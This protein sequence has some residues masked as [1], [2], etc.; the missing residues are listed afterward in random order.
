AADAASAGPIQTSSGSVAVAV[1]KVQTVAA[2]ADAAADTTSS[3][4][5]TEIVVTGSRIPQ[6]NLTSVSPIQAV[7]HQEFQLTGHTDVIDLLNTLPQNFQNNKND[8]S[9]TSNPLNGPGGVSTA[10][11]RGLGPQRTLV[12]VNG[13]R[14]GIGDPDTG[15]TNPAPDL[16]QIPVALID[17]VEV[18]TGGAS[19]TYGSDAV[20]GVV[21]F[22]MKKDFEGVQVD[23]QYGGDQHS[24]GNTAMQQAI[25]TT[26]GGHPATGDK[27][28]GQNTDFSVVFGANAPDGKGNVTGYF[29]FKNAEPVTEGDRDYSGCLLTIGPPD[30]CSNSSNSNLFTEIAPT[31]GTVF[32]VV[33]TSFLP[34]PQPGSVPPA[35]FNSSPYEFLSRQDTRY[36]GGF[37]AHYDI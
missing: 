11:L 5:V 33:G 28:D 3:T 12:L 2:A 27:W 30:R 21:N 31:P 36:L 6:P 14:L 26:G 13:R 9:N 15:D 10:D 8:F 25:T 29:E 16:D 22:I 1:S 20:A 32:S 34:R 4:A 19:A 23:G 37:F 24:N 18:L 7:S 35:T 17:H